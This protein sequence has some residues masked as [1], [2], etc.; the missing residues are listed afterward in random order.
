MQGGHL[1]LETISL[2]LSMTLEDGLEGV[3]GPA[4]PV[5]RSRIPRKRSIM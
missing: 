4:H 3:A 1:C 5:S 2:A